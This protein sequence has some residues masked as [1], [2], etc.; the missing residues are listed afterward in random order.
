MKFEIKGMP[1]H[2]CVCC[3]EADLTDADLSGVNLTGAKLTGTNF[4][5]ARR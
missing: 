3:G 5:G 2:E 4:Y 1:A